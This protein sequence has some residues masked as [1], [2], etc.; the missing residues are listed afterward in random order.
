MGYC[1]PDEIFYPMRK[2]QPEFGIDLEQIMKAAPQKKISYIFP[3]T[4]IICLSCALA[5]L[6]KPCPSSLIDR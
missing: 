3:V 6:G 2:G 1:P 4:R 5:D